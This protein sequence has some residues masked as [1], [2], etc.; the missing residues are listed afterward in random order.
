MV[1][2]IVIGFGNVGQSLATILRLRSSWFRREYGL[3]MKV[4]AVVDRGGAAIAR[5]GLDLSQVLEAKRH[6]GS[7]S[8]VKHWGKPHFSALEALEEVGG[9]IVIETSSTS[10]ES[11]EPGLSHIKSA[12]ALKKHVVTTNKGSL[13]LSLPYLIDLACR[14][15]VQ[16]RFSGA[17]G[18]GMPVLDFAK[19]ILYG[20]KIE[21]IRGVLNGT[22]NYVLWSMAEKNIELQEA[23][24][25]AQALGYT[26]KNVLYDLEGFDTACKLV[27][28]ANWVMN[29]KATLKDVE[30]RGIRG[31][32]LQDVL[33]A[34]KEGFAIRLIGSISRRMAVHPERITLRDPLC[35]GSA[36]NAVAFD[37]AY[38]GQHV[39]IGQGA[40]GRET[41]ASV[42][43]DI[44]HISRE[45]GLSDDVV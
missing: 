27:I 16:L 35:V 26:E 37:C 6:R 22:T 43:R 44:V 14:N 20:E 39:L 34:E 33:N 23:V 31:V 38:S 5:Y 25:E 7:V 15:E 24:S 4:V 40:G 41:A 17:V 21:S 12:L 9:D 18:G 29:R 13:A 2:L 10:L 45:C 36:L 32:S 28:L 19:D 8:A 42:I 11:G 1:K 3:D 30:I